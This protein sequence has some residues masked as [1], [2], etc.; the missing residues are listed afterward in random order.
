MK[1][2]ELEEK[3]KRILEKHDMQINIDGCGCC[4]SPHFDFTY[5]GEVIAA[6]ESNFVLEMV[7][8]EELRNLRDS[9]L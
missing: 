1:R 6:F 3:V 8:A 2:E 9:K 5:K 7:S 4:G